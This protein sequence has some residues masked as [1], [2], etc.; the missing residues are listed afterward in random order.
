VAP[1]R[2]LATVSEGAAKRGGQGVCG[3]CHLLIHNKA[4]HSCNAG[5]ITASNV[6]NQPGLQATLTGT[7]VVSGGS[8]T[9]A[10][11]S[12]TVDYVTPYARVR[13]VCWP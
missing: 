12:A 1:G 9:L 11:P 5:S 3:N 6:F 10:A 2:H 13:S 7:P 8:V 4:A